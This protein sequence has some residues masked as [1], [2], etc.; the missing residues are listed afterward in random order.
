MLIA[1]ASPDTEVPLN[2]RK[3]VRRIKI[4]WKRRSHLVMF[5]YCAAANFGQ[6]RNGFLEDPDILHIGCH[7]DG[8][9]LRLEFEPEGNFRPDHNSLVRLARISEKSLA[10]VV[11]NCCETA[12]LAGELTIGGGVPLAIGMDGEIPDDAAIVFTSAFYEHLALGYSVH[13]AFEEARKRLGDEARTFPKLFA[14][15][16]EARHTPLFAAPVRAE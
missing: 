16:E 8:E 1:T 12:V 13:V 14:S 3:E 6:I 9:R 4:A 5:T 10:L 15:S 2:H 7:G 11:L